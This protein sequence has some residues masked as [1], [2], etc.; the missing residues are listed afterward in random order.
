MELDVQEAE[1]SR[2]KAH[3][4][5]TSDLI[6]LW[7]DRASHEN[8]SNSNCTL[9]TTLNSC[10]LSNKYR[11]SSAFVTLANASPDPD[12]Q[13]SVHDDC[14]FRK[15]SAMVLM[16]T[17][18]KSDGVKSSVCLGRQSLNVDQKWDVFKP[19]KNVS[20]L[21]KGSTEL[22]RLRSALKLS[23]VQSPL[24]SGRNDNNFLSLESRPTQLNESRRGS[25]GL[26]RSKSVC[27][28]VKFASSEESF[29]GDLTSQSHL[30]NSTNEDNNQ[31]SL[32]VEI[33][34]DSP[35]LTRQAS[36]PSLKER[37]DSTKSSKQIPTSNP[38]CSR[39]ST[40]VARSPS[41]AKE[42]IL[43][44]VQERTNRYPG[45]NVTNFSTSW[46]NGMAFC[47][48]IHYYY[49]EAFDYNTLQ[50]ENRKKNFDLAFKSAE[51]YADICPL[52]DVEDMVKFEKPDWKCVFTYV[53]T[54]Y[55]RFRHGREPPVATKKLTLST[56]V[57]LSP[58]T[59]AKS[60]E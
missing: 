24:P 53:Q 5:K 29:K 1:M 33:S 27:H 50:P 22:P 47:A 26:G 31:Q 2:L 35:R 51:K 45:L 39:R 8:G 38:S 13:S 32:P 28:K 36:L 12:V 19:L 4:G 58:P 44:W 17:P 55:R 43:A 60:I 9:S 59:L 25:V 49:P 15:T 37:Q 34:T 57:H 41:S 7:N 40:V 54:F 48:L 56:P 11:K 3:R 18:S 10:A 52:L 6:G 23:T 16:P 20:G 21:E 30:K 42:V 46:N 14:K